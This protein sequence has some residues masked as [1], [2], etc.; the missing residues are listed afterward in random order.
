MNKTKIGIC[1]LC[2][3]EKELIPKSHIIPKFFLNRNLNKEKK[4]FTVMTLDTSV[5]KHVQD[6]IYEPHILCKICDNEI[7]SL[8][9]DYA[10][11]FLYG[12]LG[13]KDGLEIKGQ[14]HFLEVKNV[15]YQKLKLFFLSILWRCS[16]SVF[17]NDVKLDSDK[18]EYLR[19]I[20][21]SQKA[22]SE[23]DYPSI[24]WNYASVTE[25][26][27]EFILEPWIGKQVKGERN[28]HLLG[29]GMLLQI[30][31]EY[32]NLDQDSLNNLLK[33]DGSMNIP[34][35]PNDSV[36]QLI[37]KRIGWNWLK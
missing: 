11:K 27:T 16:I 25:V 28:F 24:F 4:G 9:E 37:N 29:G 23:L 2:Q 14:G 8:Y 33:E 26:S 18:E 13:K 3:N 34:S 30:I 35:T 31:L 7:L 1:K 15:D 22:P 20:L 10:C 6:Y 32:E 17:F 5:T 21:Y 12:N 19:A 36:K